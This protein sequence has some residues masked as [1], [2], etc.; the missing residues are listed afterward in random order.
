[1]GRGV[2]GGER[3]G[4]WGGGGGGGGGGGALEGKSGFQGENDTSKRLGVG[5]CFLLHSFR[6]AKC[7]CHA[8]PR[9]SRCDGVRN[10]RRL[11]TTCLLGFGFF[12]FFSNL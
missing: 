9:F 3:G 10:P 1:M 6:K 5:G 4:R 7:E 12:V 8:L 2:V 11:L